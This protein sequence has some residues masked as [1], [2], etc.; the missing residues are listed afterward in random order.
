MINWN[1]APG[2]LPQDIHPSMTPANLMAIN[3][4]GFQKPTEIGAICRPPH[5]IACNDRYNDT[6]CGTNIT[7]LKQL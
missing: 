2:V 4:L 6:I 3:H 5:P 7:L 1:I